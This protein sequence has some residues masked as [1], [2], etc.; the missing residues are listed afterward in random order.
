MG[1]W[2]WREGIFQDI[3]K[4]K[5]LIKKSMWMGLVSG[6]ILNGFYIIL[7]L[8]YDE[9]PNIWVQVAAFY[10]KTVLGNIAF[11]VFYIGAITLMLNKMKQGFFLNTL[12]AVGRTALSNYLFQSIVGTFIFYHFG[13][14]LFGFS[15]PVINLLVVVTVFVIQMLLSSLWTD[16]FKFGPAE[17]L[18]RSMTYGKLQPMRKE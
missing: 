8:V 7:R 1:V 2:A 15:S 14:G 3:E 17:W 11:C 18:W 12:A 9:A 13:L 5:K 10:A 6:I 4:H 16:R